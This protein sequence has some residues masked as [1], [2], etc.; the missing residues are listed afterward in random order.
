ML[1]DLSAPS[2]TPPVNTGLPSVSG[3]AVEGQ[4]LTASV[5]SWS[6]NPAP[7]FAFKWQRC[8]SV[9]AGCVPISGAGNATYALVAADVGSTIEVAVTA[10]NASG[11]AQANSAPTGLISS[12]PGPLTPL[13]DDFNRPDNTGPPSA[14]WSHLPVG[15]AGA[16]NNLL[17][18]SQQVTGM[19]GGSNGDYWNVAQY[20]P[21]SEA[22]I[23][24]VAKPTLDQSVVALFVRLQN[25]GLSN[26]SG[27]QAIYTFRSS[28]ADQYRIV[29]RTNG[30]IAAT[31]ASQTGPTLKAGDR[32]L[33]RAI[34]STIELWRF[35]LGSWTLL[36]SATDTTYKGAGYVALSAANNVVQVD[37]FGGGTLP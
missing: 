2:A 30:G 35:S 15:S 11:S 25:P 5:G 13:L 6:G 17:I 28:G 21:D 29:T 36:L 10:T 34:G 26:S 4:T 27:Y 23:T 7:S 32:L 22:W 3:S 12:A 24:V 16:T 31:L 19:T 8:S 14:N 20:G 33:L 37:N 1:D 18:S 9:G